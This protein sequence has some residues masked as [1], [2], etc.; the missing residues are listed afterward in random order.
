MVERGFSATISVSTSP[1][2]R[3]DRRVSAVVSSLDRRGRR[4]LPGNRSGSASTGRGK[5]SSHLARTKT[6]RKS[7]SPSVCCAGQGCGHNSAS[8]GGLEPDTRQ[9][10]NSV[11]DQNYRPKKN[12]NKHLTAQMSWKRPSRCIVHA[13]A[14][15]TH[16]S[17][18]RVPGIH[19][20]RW[21]SAPM[22]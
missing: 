2:P 13:T 14:L 7:D 3:C 10:A 18:F 8:N 12:A 5:V 11:P 22:K 20:N 4:N 16:C 1:P 9:P 15:H 21:E 19:P 17:T 6:E